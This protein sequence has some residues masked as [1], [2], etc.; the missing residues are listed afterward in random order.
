MTFEGCAFL[1]KHCE[2]FILFLPLPRIETIASIAATCGE[3]LNSDYSQHMER[4]CPEIVE[5]M[6]H[7]SASP[8]T[9]I[10]EG[11]S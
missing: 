3:V 9:Q 5:H 11:S 2:A 8:S 1:I 4:G 7:Q 6:A 10:H